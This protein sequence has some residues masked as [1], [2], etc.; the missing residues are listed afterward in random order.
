MNLTRVGFGAWAIGGAAWAAGWGPQDDQESVAAIRHA[1]EC[2][3]NWIDTAAVY[4][5]GH[6]EELV[7]RALQGYAD[8]DRPY[9][10]TKCGM[11]WDEHD[12]FVP[13]SRIG[14]PDAIRAGCEASLRRL[15]VERI[16][17]LQVHWPPTDVDVE[18][19]WSALIELRK[20]GKVRAI[21]LSNHDP[22][23]MSR[24]E[25]FGRVDVV[26][27]H[28][29]AIER[30]AG[31]V[32]IPWAR[33]H[34]AGV[35]VYSPLQSGLLSGGFTAER[36]AT[37]PADDWRCGHDDFSG[38]RLH[39]NLALADALRPVA[40]RHGVT[41]AAVAV[42]WT[43]AWDGVTGAIVGARRPEQVD[44]WRAA[45]ALVLDDADITEVAAAIRGSGAGS[46][47]AHPKA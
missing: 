43:L 20:T 42:A 7:R 13:P 40:D 5:L 22:D 23:Q 37:L 29:S 27:P 44:G 33:D 12:R 46:G 45:A 24:A 1:V 16:D 10:F 4:G 38:E 9:L 8:D 17:L 32:E 15:G 47:P 41:V 6:S 21:G 2:G 25:K 14:H 11:A 30:D 26:Q 35:I 19:C 34:A 36:A 18:D 28:F 3:V 31:A 39:R